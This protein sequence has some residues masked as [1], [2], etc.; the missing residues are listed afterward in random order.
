MAFK[1]RP[2][3]P[4]DITSIINLEKLSLPHPWCEE[5]IAS[6]VSS[7]NKI[8]LGAVA[9]DGNL[10]SYVGMSYVIDEGEIGNVC[11]H[12]DYRQMGAAM[13]VLESLKAECVAR[14]IDKI[15]L[16]VSEH[17]AGAIRLYEK[18]GYKMYSKRADY[19]GKGDSALMYMLE[20]NT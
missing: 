14:S 5:D 6:L 9:E 20:V 17:N 19:Y 4:E 7:D 15:F 16:E 3:T 11:T 12:P 10:A 1:V 8:A 2:L 18:M 13:A